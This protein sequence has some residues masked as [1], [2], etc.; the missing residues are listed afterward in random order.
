M[1][2]PPIAFLIYSL[3]S[4]GAERVV[5][6]LANDLSLT[7]DVIIITLC[8]DEPFYKLNDSIAIKQLGSFN[9][10]KNFLMI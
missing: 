3:N 4:G 9:S 10:G 1:K 6:L 8:K 2:K 5:S 7:N